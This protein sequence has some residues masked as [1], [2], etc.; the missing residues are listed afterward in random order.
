MVFSL[1]S[2]AQYFVSALR[3]SLALVFCQIFG[4]LAEFSAA[5]IAQRVKEGGVGE[6]L[7]NLFE[8]GI[9]L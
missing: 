5:R 7:E 4:N 1:S 6:I 2:V 8:K 9:E 3:A